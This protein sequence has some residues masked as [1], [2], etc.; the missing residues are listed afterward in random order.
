[1]YTL[2]MYVI[3]AHILHLYK[4]VDVTDMVLENILFG[5]LP[6]HGRVM[7]EHLLETGNTFWREGCVGGQVWPPH[8]ETRGIDT[9]L[10]SQ[11][12]GRTVAF[13]R[14][15][16]RGRTLEAWSRC[17]HHPPLLFSTVI[18]GSQHR[19]GRR[20]LGWASLPGPGPRQWDSPRPVLCPAAL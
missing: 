11:E 17:S 12:R 4:P 19:A 8:E 3:Y 20:E 18:A 9:P 16:G 13:L 1:M 6:E 2:I 10:C 5:E 14:P 15:V 7:P